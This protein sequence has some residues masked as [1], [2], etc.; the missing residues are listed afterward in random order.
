MFNQ[1]ADSADRQDQ[2][3]TREFS[4]LTGQRLKQPG[5]VAPEFCQMRGRSQLEIKDRYG[6][7]VG[8]I[9]QR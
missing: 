2:C 8:T 3:Q 7:S 4:T 9:Q 6:R 1:L 5:H